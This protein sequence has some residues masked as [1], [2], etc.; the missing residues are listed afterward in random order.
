MQRPLRILSLLLVCAA[1]AGAAAPGTLRPIAVTR[2]LA[3]GGGGARFLRTD[4]KGHL[5]LLIPKTLTVVPISAGAPVAKGQILLKAP[6]PLG[7]VIDA[8]VCS[9]PDDWVMLT[10]SPEP[11]V[12]LFMNGEE[13][14]IHQPEWSLTG[15]ACPGGTPAVAVEPAQPG[16][17]APGPLPTTPPALMLRWDGER[18]APY[19]DRLLDLRGKANGLDFVYKSLAASEVV[20]TID[21]RGRLWVGQSGFYNVRR[22]TSSGRVDTT[23]ESGPME[24]KVREQPD[25]DRKRA[26]S[27][28]QGIGAAGAKLRP[29]PITDRALLGLAEGGDASLFIFVAPRLAHGKLAIDRYS[30]GDGRV[31]RTLVEGEVGAQLA[32]FVADESGIYWADR[33]GKAWWLPADSLEK[34]RWEPAPEVRVR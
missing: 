26:E 1:T 15:V 22:I 33:T 7:T 5:Y 25:E 30:P 13:Q 27:I 17:G 2:F 16:V 14:S 29:A 12:R 31:M 11:T 24:V 34:A 32:S 8:A 20:T 19:V 10:W 3:Y 4:S 23:L 6:S 28:I 21:H 9:G 18:W